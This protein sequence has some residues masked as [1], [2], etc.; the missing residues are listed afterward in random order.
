M[1][2]DVNTQAGK[3]GIYYTIGNILLKGVLFFSLPIFTR[4][5]GTA[6]F[7][8]YN[9]YIAYEQIFTAIF[10]L[11]MYGTIKNAKIDFDTQFE[12]YFS[13]VSQLCFLFAIIVLLIANGIISLNGSFLD[14]NQFEINLLV[15]QS[16]GAA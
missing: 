11:G 10:G 2:N 6:D 8:Y 1:Q 5:M 15:L 14:F 7:G 13:F 12:R 16:F 3:A 9:N 4:I